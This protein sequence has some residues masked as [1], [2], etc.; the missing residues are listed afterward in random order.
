M[1]DKS[2][3]M[4][5]GT[6]G[7]WSGS[8]GGLDNSVQQIPEGCQIR[9]GSY[10]TGAHYGFR[11]EPRF[12]KHYRWIWPYMRKGQCRKVVGDG[13]IELSVAYNFWNEIRVCYLRLLRLIG[14]DSSPY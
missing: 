9:E 10:N 1:Q 4:T 14:H 11:F 3:L 13:N 8:V 7:G 12:S 2:Q 5:C 6:A